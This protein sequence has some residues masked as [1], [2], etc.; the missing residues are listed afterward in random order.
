MNY[1]AETVLAETVTLYNRCMGYEEYPVHY[2]TRNKDT[3]IITPHTYQHR[4]FNAAGARAALE[5][6]G[7]NA[8]VQ[9]FQD[10]IEV[11]HTHYL[12]Q[13]LSRRAKQL[14]SSV[15]SVVPVL[16]GQADSVDQADSDRPGHA[17]GHGIEAGQA[18]QVDADPQPAGAPGH[19]DPPGRRPGVRQKEGASE[20]GQAN[21]GST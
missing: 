1:S 12:E 6:I 9:A 3:G 4:S 13:V 11:S 19:S 14:E 16:P 21:A 7:R 17:P 8:G 18:S 20:G 15:V 5:L 10:N 2:S